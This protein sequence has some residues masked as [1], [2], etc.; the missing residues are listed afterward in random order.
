MGPPTQS[1]L[2]LRSRNLMASTTSEYLVTIPNRADSHIQNTA[3]GPP[4]AIAPV[5]PAMLPVPTVAARAVVTA[6]NGVTSPLPACCFLNILPTVFFMA[7]WNLRELD[8]AHPYAEIDAGA[9]QQDK[10]KR[11]PRQRI[12]LC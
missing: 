10:H 5:T 1:P 6:W 12:K 11:D 4:T 7:W 9:H 3:P 8:E 2:S